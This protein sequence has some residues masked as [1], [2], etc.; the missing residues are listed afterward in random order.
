MIRMEQLT[1]SMG[2]KDACSPNNQSDN[3]REHH[4]V[5]YAKR[6]LAFI[7]QW[8][9]RRTDPASSDGLELESGALH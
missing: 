7:V 9:E 8:C 4:S 1:V 3:S 5:D 2:Q 6:S